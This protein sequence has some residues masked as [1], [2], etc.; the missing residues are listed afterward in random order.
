MNFLKDGATAL[1]TVFGAAANKASTAI[2]EQEIEMEARRLEAEKRD[3]IFAPFKVVL[4]ALEGFPQKDGKSFVTQPDAILARFKESVKDWPDDMVVNEGSYLEAILKRPHTLA[5]GHKGKD[6][7]F[8]LTMSNSETMVINE[9]RYDQII[10]G[11]KILKGGEGSSAQKV[12]IQE[13]LKSLGAWVGKV[14]PDRA[15]EFKMLA[16]PKS[17]PRKTLETPQGFK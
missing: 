8:I 14:A 11:Q 16:G 1:R 5:V 10:K 9:L 7:L 3:A 17:T 4:S 13:A 12:S 2:H 15:D 6:E